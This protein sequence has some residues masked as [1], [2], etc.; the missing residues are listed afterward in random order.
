[1]TNDYVIMGIDTGNAMIKTAHCLFPAGLIEHGEHQPALKADSIYYNGKWYSLTSQRIPYREDKTND[2]YYFVLSLFGIAKELNARELPHTATLHLGVGLPPSHLNRYRQ[3]YLDY[4]KRSDKPIEFEYKGEKYSITI[5]KVSVFPQ[6]YAAVHKLIGQLQSETQV[7]L[8]DIGGYTTD[9]L[10]LAKDDRGLV[11]ADLSFCETFEFGTIRCYNKI[12]RNLYT[13]FHVNASDLLVQEML[14]NNNGDPECVEVAK[15][16]R[17]QYA[18]DLVTT[19]EE[20]GV[21]LRLSLPVFIGGGSQ[22][23]Q[24]SIMKCDI[25]R[26]IFVADMKENAAGYEALIRLEDSDS[27]GK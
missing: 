11:T 24:D 22:L 20:K 27:N 6:A 18:K 9:V 7:Y 26:P 10:L 2:D 23:M 17:D 13:D 16:I 15:R 8:I 1:M 21:E 14:L 4:F 3:K 5:D 19:L 25:R 12:E